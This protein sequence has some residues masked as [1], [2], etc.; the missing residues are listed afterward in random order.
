[1]TLSVGFRSNDCHA[2]QGAMRRYASHCSAFSLGI[3]HTNAAPH[4]ARPLAF[5][6]TKT[7]ALAR[8]CRTPLGGA[9][10]TLS[11]ALADVVCDDR[12]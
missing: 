12:V 1:M 11:R 2:P 6:L 5:R 4:A 10:E 9:E 8:G 7:W 3:L